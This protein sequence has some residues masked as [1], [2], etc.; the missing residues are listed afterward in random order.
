MALKERTFDRAKLAKAY[1]AG[2]MAPYQAARKMGFK[3]VGDMEEAIRIMESEEANQAQEP[4]VEDV[5]SA[6]ETGAAETPVSAPVRPVKP[7]DPKPWRP[8]YR[9]DAVVGDKAFRVERRKY[10]AEDKLR[11]LRNGSPQHME[12]ESI[13]QLD[14]VVKLLI[15]FRMLIEEENDHV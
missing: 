1:L 15:T 8:A 11:L 12:F 6:A 4:A 2:G 14:R 7:E 13:E 5:K 9:V 10:E 3:R